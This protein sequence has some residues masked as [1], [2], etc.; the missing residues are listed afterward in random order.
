MI[1]LQP[2]IK[3]KKPIKTLLY[4]PT[5][6]GKTL[7]SLY[8]AAGFVMAERKCTEEEAYKHI[9][10][11]DTEYGRGALYKDVGPYNYLQIEAPYYVEK[12]I[13][14]INELSL[15]DE[16]DVIIIDSFTHF[17]VKKGGIL[18]QKAQRDKQGGN[19]YTNWQE[20]TA[21]FNE[22]V[23]T[24]LAA[25]KHIFCTARAKSDT[26]LEDINGKKVPKT[27]GLKPELREGIEFDFDIVFNVDKETHSLITDKGVPG[28]EPVFDTP[29]PATGIHILDLVNANTVIKPRTVEDIKNSIRQISK[30]NNLIVF[31]QLK[32]SGRKLED[33]T[34]EQ[35]VQLES[36]LLAEIKRTQ[37]KRG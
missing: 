20:F 5:Y 35:L 6:S 18:D 32:L 17:W 12:L 22:T 9:V 15:M 2:A 3:F 4:G 24:I 25:P 11:I 14:H 16:I 36:D 13:A 37:V 8:L 21:K 30:N 33:L 31:V 1:T 34:E 7:C 27:Y 28:L 26:A 29:T 23:D 19:S 10:L